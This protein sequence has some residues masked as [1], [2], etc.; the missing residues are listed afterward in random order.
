MAEISALTC[1]QLLEF[2]ERGREKLAQFAEILR[3]YAGSN[4][5]AEGFIINLVRYQGVIPLTPDNVQDDIKEFRDNF[6]MMISAAR[7]LAVQYPDLILGENCGEY[8]DQALKLKAI[9]TA[10][11]GEGWEDG[12]QAHIDMAREAIRLYPSLVLS[13]NSW[14]E[15]RKGMQG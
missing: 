13:E 15:I 7:R 9:A 5:P 3:N 4:T 14:D 1:E 8:R 2:D 6:E 11:D 12:A 10:A